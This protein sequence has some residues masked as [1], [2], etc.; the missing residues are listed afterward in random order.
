MYELSVLYPPISGLRA[1][2]AWDLTHYETVDRLPFVGLHRNF[3]RH[4][5]AMGAS[6]HGA[7]FAWLAARILLRQYQGEAAKGDDLF[8]FSRVL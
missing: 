7:G 8:G 1:E 6:R 2:W 3:P 4:L 5:F